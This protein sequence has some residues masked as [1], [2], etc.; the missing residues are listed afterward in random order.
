MSSDGSERTSRSQSPFFHATQ[1]G[2]YERQ[3]RI[4]L[5]EQV[6]E[7]SLV[8]FHGR[9]EH[10]VITPFADAIGDVP[11]EGRQAL[12]VVAGGGGVGGFPVVGF[13]GHG[14]GVVLDYR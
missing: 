3:E 7:R 9:I 10:R 6:T 1:A 12:V 8:V 14:V 2:R 5:Y 11:R 4:L 13:A